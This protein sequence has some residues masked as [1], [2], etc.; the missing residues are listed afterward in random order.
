MTIA[1]NNEDEKTIETEH[2]KKVKAV[3]AEIIA[4]IPE[5]LLSKEQEV[6]LISILGQ[7]EFRDKIYALEKKEKIW[8]PESVALSILL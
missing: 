4:K 6:S 1:L 2:E 5:F 3:I 7:Q 8:S